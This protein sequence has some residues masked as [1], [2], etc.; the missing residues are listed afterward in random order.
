MIGKEAIA[1][2]VTIIVMCCVAGLA[3][4]AIWGTDTFWCAMVGTS[5]K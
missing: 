3:A 4:T 5:C 1:A 2:A